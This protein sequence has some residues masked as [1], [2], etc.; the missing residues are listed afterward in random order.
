MAAGGVQSAD[1]A[2]VARYFQQAHVVVGVETI[3]ALGAL[4]VR[5][6]E[7]FPSAN[8][9]R[10]NPHGAGHVADF[11]INLCA[12][13]HIF[14]RRFPNVPAGRATGNALFRLTGSYE[15]SNLARL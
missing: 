1:L 12:A 5:E 10:R 7:S 13:R 6:S 11:E 8:R 15:V 14:E 9:R 2:Q 3:A 4:R